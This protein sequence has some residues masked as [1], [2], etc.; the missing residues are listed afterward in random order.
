M[1]DGLHV[2]QT[3]LHFDLYRLEV[4]TLEYNT[5]P[6][7]FIVYWISLADACCF[8]EKLQNLSEA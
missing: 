1:R 5:C 3:A 6:S 2:Y 8:M 7:V 4:T